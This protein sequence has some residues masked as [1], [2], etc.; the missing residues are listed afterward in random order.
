MEIFLQILCILVGRLPVQASGLA[1]FPRF[2]TIARLELRSQGRKAQR[3]QAKGC[4]PDSPKP[5]KTRF[6]GS[7][8]RPPIRCPRFAGWVAPPPRK[9]RFRMAGQ[10]FRGGTGYPPA[11]NERFQ[12]IPSS[13]PRLRMAHR[14]PCPAPPAAVKRRFPRLATSSRLSTARPASFSAYVSSFRLERLQARMSG[15]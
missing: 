10:P 9:T 4:L 14:C 13:S 8:T 15:A 3:P 6:P 1:R 2:A 12:V 5:R 11:P 7:I